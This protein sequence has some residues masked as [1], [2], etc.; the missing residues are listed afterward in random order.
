MV[1]PELF[2]P[3]HPVRK[4]ETTLGI[5]NGENLIQGIDY[6]CRGRAEGATRKRG[7]AQSSEASRELL[8]CCWRPH[9]S[10]SW[11]HRRP[12]FTLAADGQEC[13]SMAA[14]ATATTTAPE[15]T[16]L[17]PS[18]LPLDYWW[19]LAR[20]GLWGIQFAGFQPQQYKA[21][22]EARRHQVNDT[23]PYR[24]GIPCLATCQKRG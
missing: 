15:D 3:L 6:N 13:T 5:S 9:R 18:S 8:L 17:P 2:A 7:N 16:G 19:N 22:R 21:Q 14:V 10:Q 12:G 1:A 23:C 4:A 24:A 20:K 11:L